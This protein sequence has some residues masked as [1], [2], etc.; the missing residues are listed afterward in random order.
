MNAIVISIVFATLLNNNQENS[1]FMQLPQP[2]KIS[3]FD[4]FW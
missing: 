1:V 2:C 3:H 4:D